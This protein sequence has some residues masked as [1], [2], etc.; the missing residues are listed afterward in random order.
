MRELGIPL[1]TYR[2]PGKYGKTVAAYKFGDIKNIT[3]SKSSGRTALSKEIKQALIQK[4]GAKCFIYLESMDPDSLQIDHRIPY[5][6]GGESRDIDAFML[7][8][9]SANRAKSWT[10]EHCVN[11]TKKE[12]QFCMRCFW[13]FPENYDHVAG[14][15]QKIISILFT[16]DEIEDYKKLIAL[17]GEN[18]VQEV[19]KK[20]L[21]QYFN[22]NN[23]D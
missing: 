10:C 18:S 15:K 2:V 4:Y 6:I 14:K 9:P 21:R 22:H 20:I 8:S 5:E 23:I 11:W 16:G 17:S 19:I 7:L 12:V 1:V 13:A 3:L